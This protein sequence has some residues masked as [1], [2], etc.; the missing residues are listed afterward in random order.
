MKNN[1]SVR[2]FKSL[3]SV[4]GLNNTQFID[5]LAE[6]LFNHVMSGKSVDSGMQKINYLKSLRN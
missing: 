2:K 5:Y 3:K 4:M 6:I 1:L